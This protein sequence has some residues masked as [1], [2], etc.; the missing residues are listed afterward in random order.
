MEPAGAG[1]EEESHKFGVFRFSLG[2][3]C[4]VGRMTCP[5]LAN[6]LLGLSSAML[7]GWADTYTSSHD[8]EAQRTGYLG[9]A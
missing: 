8:Q 4:P 5:T 2:S 7:G 6:R 9:H 1:D 3:P